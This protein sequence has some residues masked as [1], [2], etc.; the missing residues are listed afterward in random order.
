[1]K[2]AYETPM[3]EM[4]AFR[5]RDQVVA[6][7]GVATADNN[8]TGS[9]QN[10]FGYLCDASQKFSSGGIDGHVCNWFPFA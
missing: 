9:A 5:Y 8:S 7:S 6:A 2:K 10:G 1:M 3:V 4:I